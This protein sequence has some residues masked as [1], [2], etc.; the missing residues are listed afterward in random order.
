MIAQPV[1][2]Y[3]PV[4]EAIKAYL[5]RW[6]PTNDTRFYLNSAESYALINGADGVRSYVVDLAT[7]LWNDRS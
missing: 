3:D 4:A 1:D 5:N 6:F 7:E 2:R